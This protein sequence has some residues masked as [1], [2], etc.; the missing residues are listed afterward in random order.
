MLLQN[1]YVVLL[2]P[3]E[4]DGKINA[5]L[6]NPSWSQRVIYIQGSALRVSDLVRAKVHYAESCFIFSS[7]NVK[8]RR[9]EVGMLV[10]V[11]NASFP[12]LFL[13]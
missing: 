4:F 10:V 9:R 7:R 1:Y 6:E 13:P 2:C 12:L 8:D 3:L 11:F 5:M